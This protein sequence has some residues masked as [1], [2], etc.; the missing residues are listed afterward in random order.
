LTERQREGMS[1]SRELPRDR[2][3]EQ[4][5]TAEIES[6]RARLRG[7]VA[8]TPIVR[9]AGSPDDPPVNQKQENQQPAGSFK[10]RPIGNAILSRPPDAV[11]AGVH[12]F[13]SGNSALALAWMARR[14]GT[15]ATAVVPEGA[16]ESKLELIRSLDARIIHPPFADWWSAVTSGRC[17]QFDTLYIDAV[18]DPAALAGSG[19]LAAEILE[20]VPDVEAIF[21]PFGGGGLACGV[22]NALRASGSAAK[23]IVCEL[24]SAH[25]FKSAREAGGPVAA[26]CDPG[27]VTG[28]GF[29]AVLAEMWPVAS[30]LVDDTLTVSLS[31]VVDAIKLL[32]TGNHVVAEGAGAIPVAAALSNRHRFRSVCAVV[33]G[34][35]LDPALLAKILRGEDPR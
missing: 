14:V 5:G 30:R 9:C 10:L 2:W 21:V 25:P 1:V 13:S 33:S 29:G 12:T 34:G 8:R 15:P 17:S 6:A 26:P 18:R 35:N 3:L 28:V 16:S 4:I 7:V 20:D 23:V 31:E 11:R 24:E 22:A 27:F 32:A 19:T